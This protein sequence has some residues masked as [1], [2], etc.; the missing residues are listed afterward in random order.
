MATS[1]STTH[2]APCAACK[3]LRR[4]C[5][6][7]CVFAPYFPPEEPQ[8]FSNVHKVFGASNVNKLLSELL[9]GQREDAVNSLAYEA[10]SRIKDPVYGCV[11]VISVLQRQVHRLQKELDATRAELLRYVCGDLPPDRIPLVVSNA[12][13]YFHHSQQQQQH[14]HQQLQAHSFDSQSLTAL[15]NCSTGSATSGDINQREGPEEGTLR[16][17]PHI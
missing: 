14:Q 13:A 9:P 2:G 6:P 1:S 7:G 3:F 17:D 16:V 5:M 4:K 12:R 10:E 15:W 8:R 11:G